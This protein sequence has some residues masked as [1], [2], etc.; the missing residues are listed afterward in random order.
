M[1]TFKRMLSSAYPGMKQSK[2]LF[3]LMIAFLCI[4]AGEERAVITFSQ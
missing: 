3:S 4:F 2:Q 1:K